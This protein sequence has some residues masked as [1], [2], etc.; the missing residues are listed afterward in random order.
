MLRPPVILLFVCLALFITVYDA[1]ATSRQP[2]E[3]NYTKSI[4]A[5]KSKTVSVSK[6]AAKAPS[7]SNIA[8][9]AK[10]PSQKKKQQI[11]VSAKSKSTKAK[12]SNTRNGKKASRD[13]ARQPAVHEGFSET[14]HSVLAVLSTIP[15]DGDISSFF[16]PRRLSR[17]TK[18]ARMHTGI[19]ITA[20][21]GEPVLAAASGVVCFVGRW[22]AYGK[23][24]EI[25]HGNGLVTRYAHLDR[26]T[27]KE[28]DKVASGDQIGTVGRT[29]RTT[30]AHL[31]FETLV[32]GR[33]VDP[34]RAEIWQQA[35]EQIAAKRNT[36]VSGLQSASKRAY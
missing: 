8:S 36:Y 23:I 27:I 34:M 4:K 31:H 33:M 20:A 14:P 15:V 10:K 28:G 6:E 18:G 9:D 30:G 16:G 5:T 21:R 3:A 24:V 17:K 2:G 11:Q 1:S 32:N 22:A 7:K 19:D 26:Q 35:R 29:G 13:P 25:D 12:V